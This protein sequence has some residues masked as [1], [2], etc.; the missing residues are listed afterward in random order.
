MEQLVSL[1]KKTELFRDL[2]EELIRRDVLHRGQLQEVPKGGF[3]IVPQ[4]RVD[5]FGVILQGKIQVVHIYPDGS[6]GLMTTLRQEEI[7]G[8]DLVCTRSQISPYHAIAVTQSRVLYVPVTL[9]TQRGLLAEEYRLAALNRLLNLIANENMKKEY[10]LAILS[11]RGLR[12]RIITYLTMQAK[13]R[14]TNSFTISFSREEMADYLCVNR[15][16][17]SHELSLMRDE[18][19]IDFQ[20]NRFTLYKP[21]EI[22]FS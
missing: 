21:L 8:A 1:L 2:P 7:L 20:K 12:E 18:G 6:Y 10:R 3:V 19:L 11:Q 5:H 22:E 9:L 15:S 13:R 17:L 4:Q 16:A 14:R